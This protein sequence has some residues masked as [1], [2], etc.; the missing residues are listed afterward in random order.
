MGLDV[1]QDLR[2]GGDH[3]SS[4]RRRKALSKCDA[5]QGQALG[6]GEGDAQSLAAIAAAARLG[7]WPSISAEVLS[8]QR[9]GVKEEFFE[10]GHLTC[11]NQA[12]CLV[13][14]FSAVLLD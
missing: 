10:R 14:Q 8:R 7:G 3:C 5:G 12:L 2:G 1:H 6:N 11:P 9:R 13:L 4:R